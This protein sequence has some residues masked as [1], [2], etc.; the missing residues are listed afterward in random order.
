MSV[1]D[2]TLTNHGSHQV[3]GGTLKTFVDAINISTVSGQIFMIPTANGLQ[4][5]VLEVEQE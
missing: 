2:L 1:G 3:S 5:T 4:V